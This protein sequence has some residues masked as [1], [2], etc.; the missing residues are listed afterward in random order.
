VTLAF[1]A[2]RDLANSTRWPDW[3]PTSEFKPVRA[4]TA[5]VR[6]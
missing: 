1:E 5:A 3:N 4:K 2:G 6:K